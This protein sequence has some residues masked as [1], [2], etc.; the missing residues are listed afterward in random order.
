[1]STMTRAGLTAAWLMFSP[2]I[3]A[4]TAPF[5]DVTS[6]HVPPGPDLH[7]LDAAMLDVD[8]DGDLDI[9]VAVENGPNALY[10]NDGKGGLRWQPAVFNP[11]PADNEHVRSADFDG[12]GHA[13]LIFVAEDDKAHQL[14]FG[15]GR[16]RFVER[17]ERLP[18]RHQG[19]GL[20]V[21]DVNG[22]GL[23]DIVVGNT[24]DRE[25]APVR[26]SLWLNDSR[27]PGHFIDASADHLPPMQA[28]TQGV[29]L[30]DMDGDGDLDMLIASEA[31]PNRLLLNDGKGR[32]TD[33]SDRLELKQPLHSREVHVLDANGDGHNDIVFFNLTSNAGAREKDPQARLLLNDGNGRFR[34]HSA[35]LPRHDWSS[36]GGIIIDF[37]H[38]G[39][40]DILI[41]AIQVPGFVPLQV[42]AWRNDGNGNFNDVTL[43]VMPMDTVGRSWSMAAGDLDGDDKPDVFIGGWRSQAR[44]L[45]TNAAVL[46][47]RRAAPTP[48]AVAPQATHAQD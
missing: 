33:A 47:P 36:W 3:E 32:F 2:G 16:G 21:G 10:L 30:A 39:D 48:S 35:Q 9:A 12:D 17:S 4:G 27:K 18:A 41:G 37:D 11:K 26:D 31:P 13:D 40:P 20:A 19:N 22:D 5:T 42:R 44:L 6:T 28:H 1:M 15:D 25:S 7:A 34:D 24:P 45:L 23:P 46:P 38:D 8:G 43:D 29:A 14:Y